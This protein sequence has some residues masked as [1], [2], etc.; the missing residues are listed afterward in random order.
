MLIR[1]QNLSSVLPALLVSV[2]LQALPEEEPTRVPG[3]N[4]HPDKK[5]ITQAWAKDYK[6]K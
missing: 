2:P 1:I 6:S 4:I 3:K 5:V